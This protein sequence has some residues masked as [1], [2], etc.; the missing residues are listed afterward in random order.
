M[1]MNELP[2]FVDGQET[3]GMTSHIGITYLRSKTD[4]RVEHAAVIDKARV[5]RNIFSRM[6]S[7]STTMDGVHN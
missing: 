6:T 7:V 5:P 1:L 3:G 4:E 2:S